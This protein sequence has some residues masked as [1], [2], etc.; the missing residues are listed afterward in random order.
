MTFFSI[1][2]ILQPLTSKTICHS[3]LIRN[4]AVAPPPAQVPPLAAN[5]YA[6]AANSNGATP[7][8]RS[9]S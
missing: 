9:G 3:A 5:T 2:V 4:A 7:G 8:W 1:P 6:L